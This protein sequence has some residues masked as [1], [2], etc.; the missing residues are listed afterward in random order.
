MARDALSTRLESLRTQYETLDALALD[1]LSIPLRFQDPWDQEMAAWV[2]AHL[3]YGRVAP[4]LRA[5]EGILAPLGPSPAAWLRQAG[6]ADLARFER[7]LGDWKWRFH[8]GQ[9][10][11]HWC[12]AWKRLDME[13]G[14]R[15]LEPHLAPSDPAGADGRLS[16][17]VHRLRRELPPS[18]GLRFSLPDPLEGSACKRWR[19]FLRWMVRSGWPD[20]GLW[21]SYPPDALVIPLDTHVARISRFIGLTRRRTPDGR[22][23]REIT[24]ALRILDPADPLNFDFALSHLGILGDCPGFRRPES[25]RA[26]P[27]EALCTARK[28]S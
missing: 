12:L 26:C 16:A 13:S 14:G 20:L 22:M 1:P 2:A 6:T 4:M 25:C 5:I 24:E 9:D 27:L 21:Q 10:L 8:T 23:A 7:A 19:M 18:R 11:L 15:G 17:L 3:A 28:G